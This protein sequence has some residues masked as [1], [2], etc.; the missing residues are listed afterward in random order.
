MCLLSLVGTCLPAAAAPGPS[1]APEWWFDSWRVPQL[2]DSGARGQGVVI[3]EI[4]TGVN[5]ALP[6]LSGRI[7]PGKDFGPDGGNGQVDRD[8][9]D[10]G[11]GTAMASIMVGRPG[12]FG[13]T[14]LAPGARIL[15]VA[16]PLVGTTD[17]TDDDRLG[18]AIEWAAEH[19]AKIISMS[20]GGARSAA[21]TNEPCTPDEQ[22]AILDALAKGILVFAASGNSGNHGNAVSEPAVCLGVA[23]VGAVDRAGDVAD[24]S[25]R[26]RYVAFVAPGVNV[27]S[28]GRIPGEAYSGDGTSQATAIAAAVAALVWS[29][30]PKLSAAQVLARMFATLDDR[31]STPDRAYGY[32]ALDAYGA[33]T[34][35]VP[36][37]AADPVAAAAA[38]FVARQ[39]AFA[40]AVGQPE[41]A[42][43][44]RAGTL[45]GRFVV[46]SPPGRVNRGVV[47]GGVLAGVGLLGL[48]ALVTLR[49]RSRRRAT[50]AGVPAPPVQEVPPPWP[51][52]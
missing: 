37:G 47:G 15:P 29:R 3:G 4:D 40:T 25:G 28:L 18:S 48:L 45:T 14:G 27:P 33:V 6:A 41:V 5:A 26:H 34:A 39:R 21:R 11:H 35:A 46:G 44:A 9:S 31:R 24:F 2:W 16:V 52:R 38:P 43:A 20:L 30:Y 36:P 13:I 10:F 12:D 22:Q 7:L 32:G 19:G 50:P 17:A 1:D 8:S 42:P 49:L 51:P 23:A